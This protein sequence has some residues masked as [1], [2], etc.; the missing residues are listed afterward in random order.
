MNIPHSIYLRMIIS[1]NPGK[2]EI[3]PTK[4]LAF[5]R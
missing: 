5:F 3:S 4:K 2:K 1:T